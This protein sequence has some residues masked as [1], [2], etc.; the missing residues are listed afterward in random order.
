MAVWELRLQGARR[1]WPC[2]LWKDKAGQNKVIV[3][4]AM[5]AG[6]SLLGA[7][8][9]PAW[10]SWPLRY[11][12]PQICTCVRPHPAT[13][14]AGGQR[15]SVESCEQAKTH[16]LRGWG[17]VGVGG[18]GG[19]A[20]WAGLGCRWGFSARGK[21]FRKQKHKSEL[22]PGG[23]TKGLSPCPCPSGPAG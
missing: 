22:G 2:W 21:V 20:G 7:R 6:R 16:G 13:Q 11:S 19:E 14:T 3:K 15:C 12:R 23:N 1:L 17:G 4:S 8:R 10:V 5:G 9:H 18:W